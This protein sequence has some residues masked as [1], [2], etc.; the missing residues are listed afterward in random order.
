MLVLALLGGVRFDV[1]AD[2]VASGWAGVLGAGWASGAGAGGFRRRDWLGGRR[3]EAP[4]PSADAC[5]CLGRMSGP[6]AGV[7][8]LTDVN[9]VSLAS[10]CRDLAGHM[11]D[12]PPRVTVWHRNEH[13]SCHGV[14][15]SAGARDKRGS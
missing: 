1:F 4:K 3:A 2:W 8:P 12:E 15:M 7:Q 11:V 6:T 9:G 14:A 10:G 13:H 5:T